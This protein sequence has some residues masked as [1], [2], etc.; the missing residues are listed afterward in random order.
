VIT[1]NILLET[2]ILTFAPN[3]YY[4]HDDPLIKDFY[5]E[6]PKEINFKNCRQAIISLNIQ[7]KKSQTT[8]NGLKY[9][10]KNFCKTNLLINTITPLLDNQSH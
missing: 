8:G 2:P 7:K 6:Y 4:K 3:I 1:E 10:L 5:C 9:V